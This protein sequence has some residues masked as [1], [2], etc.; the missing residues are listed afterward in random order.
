MILPQTM[1]YDFV[2]LY[3]SF[4]LT[5]NSNVVVIDDNVAKKKNKTPEPFNTELIPKKYDNKIVII[6]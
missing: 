1:N 2:I 4:S 5:I 3:F 6:V